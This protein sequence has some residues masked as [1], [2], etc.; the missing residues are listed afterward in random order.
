MVIGTPLLFICYL[1]VLERWSASAA[2]YQFVLF[3]PVSVVLGAVLLG[4]SVTTGLLVGVPFVLAGVYIGA[5][6]SAARR[7]AEATRPP[8]TDAALSPTPR[9]TGP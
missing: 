3:P 8:H 6:S 4:E 9:T 7:D 5:L 2:S 1:T